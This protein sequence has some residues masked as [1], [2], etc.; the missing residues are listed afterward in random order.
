M[1]RCEKMMINLMDGFDKHLDPEKKIL[2]LEECGRKC[3][4]DR[5][6]KLIQ[7]AKSLYKNSNDMKEFLGKLSKI[8][9]SL[10][11]TKEEVAFI[12]DKCYCPVINKIP[13]GKISPTFCNCSRGW[14]KE[15]LETA[16]EKP[17]EVILEETVT[18]GNSR[19]K[20]RVLI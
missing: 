13:A 6:K 9:D 12:W 19:C 2:L 11:I 16:I 7:D 10:Q 18:K 3:I 14:V 1:E 4:H 5:H 15:L 17:V 20:L 8:Y